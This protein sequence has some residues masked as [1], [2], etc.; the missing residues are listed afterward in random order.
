[1]NYKKISFFLI[2]L[3]FFS[4]KK[5][6]SEPEKKQIISQEITPKDSIVSIVEDFHYF[7]QLLERKQ[8]NLVKKLKHATQTQAD[9]LLFEYQKIF[10]EIL[11]NLCRKEGSTLNYF[12][13]N[14]TEI[15]PDSLLNKVQVLDHVGVYYKPQ[16]SVYLL[17]FKPDFYLFFFRDK[18]SADVKKFLELKEKEELQIISANSTKEKSLQELRQLVLDWEYF[19]VKYPGAKQKD[20]AK[21]IYLNHL[22]NYLFGTKEFPSIIF[23]SKKMT[24]KNEQEFILMIKSHPKTISGKLTKEFMD[25]FLKNKNNFKSEELE[26]KL[27]DYIKNQ[28]KKSI[29]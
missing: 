15:L 9:D 25:F 23:S 12:K 5:E 16:D 27:K 28:I 19:L 24:F 1:M 21:E 18:V 17:S 22:K 6:F 2:V 20:L 26:K 7:V 13:L 8:N 14:A 11:Q 10:S 4:C 29:H 3:G